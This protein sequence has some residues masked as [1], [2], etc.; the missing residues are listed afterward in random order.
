MNFKAI[1]VTLL[2]LIVSLAVIHYVAPAAL[3]VH[4]GVS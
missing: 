3:K 2:T 1:G 4:L